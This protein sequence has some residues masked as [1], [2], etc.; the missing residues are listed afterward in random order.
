MKIN[1]IPIVAGI[2]SV[3]MLCGLVGC[4][5]KGL[6]S[7]DAAADSIESQQAFEKMEP[8]LP[9]NAESIDK[10]AKLKLISS[11]GGVIY[12]GPAFTKDGFYEILLGKD[13]SSGTG[14]LAYTDYESKT[15]I[16]LSSDVNSTH[17]DASD[18]SFLPSLTG[19]YGIITDQQRL[20]VVK[21]GDP[22]LF[23]YYG[24]NGLP[25]LYRM[26]LDGSNRQ[27]IKLAPNEEIVATSGILAD[28]EKNELY[29]LITET[30]ED[31]TTK[32]YLAKTNFDTG[33]IERVCCTNEF[34]DGFVYAVGAEEDSI[35]FVKNYYDS[36]SF[37]SRWDFFGYSLSDSSWERIGNLNADDSYPLYRDGQIY[38]I[39]SN[40]F[41]LYRL[42]PGEETD[43][44][45]NA[46]LNPPYSYDTV[47]VGR[48]SLDPFF[49]FYLSNQENGDG[50]RLCWNEENGKWYI[51]RLVRDN[52]DVSIA[53]QFN[54]QY[55]VRIEDKR[56]DYQAQ[57]E[58]GTVR[59]LSMLV[60]QYALI[61]KEDYWNG[62][63]NYT[64][65]T[66]TIYP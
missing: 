11:P 44:V 52:H 42:V 36:E 10:V 31:T 43:E 37:I 26:Q 19:G 65:F 33:T 1:L 51:E 2:L 53:G 45:I 14:N 41:S 4:S 63:P 15:R 8:T 59:Q 18:T 60:A 23:D 12:T 46:N 48:Q 21:L 61:N 34:V 9:K 50:A 62:I 39:K 28:D 24:E 38:Y 58:D 3:S 54:N 5:R 7:S 29:F 17:Q 55:V 47:Q 30:S 56:V 32:E 13:V 57:L 49:S 22:Y 20:Y 35:Y 6:G 27:Q 16:Y 66:D 40:P 25:V 64:L